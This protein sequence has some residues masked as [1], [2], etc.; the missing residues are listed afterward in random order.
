MYKNTK[1]NK[2]IFSNIKI[3][4]MKW[5]LTEDNKLSVLYE[6]QRAYYWL[7]YVNTES[8]EFTKAKKEIIK[9]YN[10]KIVKHIVLTFTAIKELNEIKNKHI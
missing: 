1:D 10:V 9:G 2:I 7:G 4:W 5:I 6:T 3:K 8:G